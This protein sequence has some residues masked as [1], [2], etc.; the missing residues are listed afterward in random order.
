MN[1]VVIVIGHCRGQTWMAFNISCRQ[2]PNCTALYCRIIQVE[3]FLARRPEKYLEHVNQGEYTMNRH[4]GRS[5]NVAS[6]VEVSR[7]SEMGGL[8]RV[9][10]K[11]SSP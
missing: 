2:V 11:A 8:S 7:E 5:L 4:M 3:P 6:H 9:P 1:Y 10:G